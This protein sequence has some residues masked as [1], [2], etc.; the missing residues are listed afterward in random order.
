MNRNDLKNK[1]AALTLALAN[2]RQRYSSTSWVDESEEMM[3]DYLLLLE[4]EIDRLNDELT[5]L[6]KE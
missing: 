5:K 4:E 2:A 3:F 6:T 1:I